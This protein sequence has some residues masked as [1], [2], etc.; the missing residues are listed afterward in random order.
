MNRREILALFGVA[1]LDRAQDVHASLARPARPARIPSPMIVQISDRI[2]PAT[3]TIGAIGARVPEFIEQFAATWYNDTERTRFNGW[4]NAIDAHSTATRGR[5]FTELTPEEQTAL[6]TDLD[7]RDGAEG[8]PERAFAGLKSLVVFGY[9]TSEV[10]QRDVLHHNPTP[11]RFD[12]C[13]P[14]TG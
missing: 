6:L 7:S 10:V 13:V 4:L 8:T 1:A 3:D 14:I 12:G 11:G 5:V 2:L 9:F